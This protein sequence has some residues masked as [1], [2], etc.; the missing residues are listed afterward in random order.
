M[1]S[2]KSTP[3]AKQPGLK[4]SDTSIEILVIIDTDKLQQAYPQGGSKDYNNPTG[5]GH[6]FEYM[7]CAGAPS[8]QA[9]SGDLT[10]QAKPGD[11]VSFFGTSIYDNADA[12][13]IIYGIVPA[14]GQ[15]NVF[16]KFEVELITRRNA[17]QPNPNTDSGIPAITG[18]VTFSTLTSRVKQSGQELYII[19]FGMYVLADDGET[20]QLFGYFQWDPTIIVK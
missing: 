17:V 5:I 9:G 8:T 19:Q 18:P 16:N 10:F 2:T 6:N 1:S 12:A 14:N 20:Q 13:V 11:F 15:P 3:G 4:A 7:Y